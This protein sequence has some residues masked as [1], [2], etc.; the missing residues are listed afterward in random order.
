MKDGAVH[1]D[2]PGVVRGGAPDVVERVALGQR[3]RPAPLVYAAQSGEA[4]AVGPVPTA[5]EIRLVATA[6]LAD[7]GHATVW[8]SPNGS[9]G[10]CQA[11]SP[12]PQ[13]K[14]NQRCMF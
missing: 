7:P 12:E 10:A 5:A 1:T 11:R 6:V 14:K 13:Q 9:T 8:D 3:I 4:S 2:R